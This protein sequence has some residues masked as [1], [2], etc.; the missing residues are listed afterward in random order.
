MGLYAPIATPS[1]SAIAAAI[2]KPPSTRHT[3]IPMSCANPIFASRVHPLSTMVIGSARKVLGTKPPSVIAAHASTKSTKKLK[4]SPARTPGWTGSSG[5]MW[6]TLL[7]EARVCELGKIG[8][9]L[10]DPDLEQQSRRVLAERRE[11]AGEELLVCCAVLPAQILLAGLEL[12]AG[13]LHI[14]AHDLEAFLR[15]L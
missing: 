12:L 7:D 15:V 1:G 9:L 2:T 5:L 13:L 11:L 3:V 14:G 4:P 8:H 10:D 6:R